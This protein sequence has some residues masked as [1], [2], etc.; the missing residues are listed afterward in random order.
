[1][2]ECHLLLCQHRTCVH[3]RRALESQSK[4]V[5]SHFTTHRVAPISTLRNHPTYVDQVRTQDIEKCPKKTHRLPTQSQ[6]SIFCA[7]LEIICGH[8]SCNH[9]VLE[10]TRSC[11][12]GTLC[13]R[14]TLS[15]STITWSICS[16]LSAQY[17][18]S[19]TFGYLAEQASLTIPST[20]S[21]SRALMERLR[22][23]ERGHSFSPR[24]MKLKRTIRMKYSVT[25][26]SQRSR[27]SSSAAK[28]TR[29]TVG[30]ATAGSARKSP[31]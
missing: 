10:W 2:H 3:F 5:F 22:R 16:I 25:L 4:T 23:Q 11:T 13:T 9:R 18:S 19:S 26:R 7:L 1:M 30:S 12:T 20:D 15:T 27:S 21:A 14:A 24:E 6:G 17:R 8:T 28:R 29:G 31:C